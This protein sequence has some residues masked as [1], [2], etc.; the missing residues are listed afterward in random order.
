VRTRRLLVGFLLWACAVQAQT[1]PLPPGTGFEWEQVGD[2]DDVGAHDLWFDAGGTLWVP[3]RPPMWLDLRGGWPGIWQEPDPLLPQPFGDAILTLGGHPTGGLPRA[4]TVLV[5]F[6]DTRRSTDGSETW[7]GFLA[8]NTDYAL[9][10]IPAGL[11]HAGRLLAGNF[12]SLSD[13]RGAT[14]RDSLYTLD[15]LPFAAYGF[16]ALPA[17]DGLPGAAS[18][19]DPAAPPGWPTGRVVAV[20]YNALAI[21][22]DDGGESWRATANGI[23]PGRRSPAVVLVRR[24]DT[25]PLGPGP[26]LLRV[27][28]GEATATSVW[29]SDDAGETWTRIALLSEPSDGPGWPSPATVLALP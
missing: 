23:E 12:I 4:D 13:D 10:E 16:L 25:H 5:T 15:G 11:P 17:P 19:R 7:S 22:S 27:G 29:V 8:E 21:L 3:E 20:G 2:R 14:W 1:L 18:S 26:R 24:P 28:S 6:G 9:Y